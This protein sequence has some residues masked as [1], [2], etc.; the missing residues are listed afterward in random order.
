MRLTMHEYGTA[1]NT[2]IYHGIH[3][4]T[5][6]HTHTQ[7]ESEEEEEFESIATDPL[8]FSREEFDTGKHIHFQSLNLFHFPIFAL[9]FNFNLNT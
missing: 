5:H 7:A 2:H 4:H 8:V 6:T 9:S 1:I 3:T